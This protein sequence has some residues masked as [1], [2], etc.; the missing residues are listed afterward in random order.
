MD[1]F[2]KNLKETLEAVNAI[3]DKKMITINSKRVRQ[4][5][6]IPSS[7]RSK[8]SFIWRTLR[9]LET[10]GILTPNGINNPKTY[11]IVI[12]EK[13]DIAKFLLKEEK[14]KKNNKNP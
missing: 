4:Y 1:F 12:K 8:I 9:Y 2:S 11:K 6:N 14:N 3:I 7:N 10:A 13:I 5:H